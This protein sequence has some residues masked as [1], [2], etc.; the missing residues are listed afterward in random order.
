MATGDLGFLDRA[1]RLTVTGRRDDIIN[2]GGFKISPHLI[3]AAVLGHPGVSAAA[4]FPVP[5]EDLGSL[6]GLV[7]S[8]VAG[9]EVTV[10]EVRAFLGTAL[11][12]RLWPDRI[13]VAA[14][15]PTNDR[16]KVARRTLATVV[17]GASPA[18]PAGSE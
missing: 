1:G 4:A 5:N 12:R 17:L 3:E 9:G 16:G 18:P 8:P 7:V 10:K 14:S 15:I 6:V 13:V 2:R 11:P